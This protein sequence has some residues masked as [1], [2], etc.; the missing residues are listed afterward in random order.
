MSQQNA[1]LVLGLQKGAGDAEIKNAYVNLVKKYDPERH[2]ERFMVIQNAYNRL[3][4]K[5]KR[6]K[7]DIHTYNVLKGDFMFSGDERLPEGVAAPT[8]E[9][10]ENARRDNQESGGSG[11]D[12]ARLVTL[13]M[14][15]SHDAVKRK[16]WTKAIALWEEVGNADPSHVRARTNLITAC[17]SLGLTYALHGLDEEAIDLWERGLRL[18]PDNPELIHNLALACEKAGA[19]DKAAKYWAEAVTRW[20]KLLKERGEDEYL[21]EC[22]VEAHRYHGGQLSSSESSEDKSVAMNRYREVLKLKPDDFE[23]RYQIASTLMEE[24]KFDEARSELMELAKKHPKNVEV[25]NLLG[26]ALLNG[27]QVDQA[28]TAWNRSMAIDPKNPRTRDNVV[29]AHLMLGKQFR[30]KGL[31]VA[32]LTHLKKL[33]RYMPKSVEV[34]MEIAATYDMKGDVRS[35]QRSYEQ[36]L[37]ID[38]KNQVARK[39]LNDLRLRR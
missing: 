39:A 20:Q 5:K 3:K 30:Q 13:L 19:S 6:A 33:Q 7:E 17:G 2:T 31:F 34:Y 4:D 18:D 26:W 16:L 15:S 24:G 29:R 28:F 38:P 37:A 32:A 27:G 11:K 10:I 12:K 25:L 14:R 23:A 8:D 22:I 35:A 1:Y 21:R 9:E 36:V